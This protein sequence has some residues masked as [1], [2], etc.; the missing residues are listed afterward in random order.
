M[1]TLILPLIVFG[2]QGLLL[3][4]DEFVF[5][6]RREVPRW[7]RIGHPLDTLTVLIP[8]VITVFL[9]AEN[10]WIATFITLGIF[11]CL[12]IAKDEWVHARLC[13]G[14]EQWLHALLFVLHPLLFIAAWVLWKSGETGWLAGQMILTAAFM[15]Y[16]TVYWNYIHAS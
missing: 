1:L 2:A 5:H 16:Q 7:E 8:L 11:S 4:M 15:I 13:S 6:Y 10:P 12:F 14:G 3:I 9:P